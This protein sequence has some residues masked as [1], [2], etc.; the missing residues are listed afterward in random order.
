MSRWYFAVPILLMVLAMLAACGGDDDGGEGPTGD[1]GPSAT[2]SGTPADSPEYSGVI[3]T[4]ELTT[5]PNRF[6][7]GVIDNSSNQPIQGAEV[8]LRFF[9]VLEGNQAELRSEAEAR[10]VSMQRGYIDEQTGELVGDGEI[11]VYVANPEFDE[12]G[13]WGVE[14]SGTAAGNEIEPIT[15]AFQVQDPEAVL[16]VGDPAPKSRQTLASDVDDIS[17]IDTMQP[18]DPMHDVTIEDAVMS[19]MPTVILFGTPAFCETQTCGPVMQSVMLPLYDEYGSQANF[20]H[21]EP[22]FVEEARTGAGFCPVPV[23]NAEFA[24]RGIGEGSGTC[25]PVPEEEIEAAGESWN[26]T[27]EPVIFVVDGEGNIAGK[28]EAVTGPEE[29][30]QV[31]AGLL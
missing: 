22:Y 20:I 9:K 12:I 8:S 6:S 19:G 21:V 23:F 11:A 17:E 5:G 30:E 13:D 2:D 26:L 25:T 28:F 3:V 14:I 24:R 15:L 31:L 4:T 29:V 1:D 7:V 16:N 10:E 18:P 27:V